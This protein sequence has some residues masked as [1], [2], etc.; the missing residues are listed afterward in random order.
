MNLPIIF[1]GVVLS[2]LYGAI[3]HFWKGGSLLHF[4]F[5]LCLSWFG[6]WV[7]HFLGGTLKFSFGAI[8][9]LNT[10]MATIGSF[11]FLF[12]GKW[13]SMVNVQRKT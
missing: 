13:L 6:F 11:F 7:G 5:F 8:G 4:V 1:L 12:A 9:L 3:F 10:G 2:T